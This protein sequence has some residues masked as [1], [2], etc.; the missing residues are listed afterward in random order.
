M[1][2][3]QKQLREALDKVAQDAATFGRIANWLLYCV[4]SFAAFVLAWLGDLISASSNLRPIY[5]FGSALLVLFALH[6]AP[7]ILIDRP[8]LW[9]T[10]WR[11]RRLLIER[12]L[13][14]SAQAFHFEP[15]TGTIR[16]LT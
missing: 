16:H 14:E 15:D 11:Y 9:L 3:A 12:S 1:A 10:Q 13:V 8:K 7:Q 6:Q 4:Y 5:Y 2:G